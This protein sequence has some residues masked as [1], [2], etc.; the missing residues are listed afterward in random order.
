MSLLLKVT[1]VM[2]L[3]YETSI[4]QSSDHENSNLIN[5]KSSLQFESYLLYIPLG[6]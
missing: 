6:D 4:L 5:I 3:D 2:K 1:L